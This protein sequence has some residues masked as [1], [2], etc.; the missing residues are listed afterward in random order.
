MT[1]TTLAGIGAY[2]ELRK[3]IVFTESSLKP[4]SFHTTV[5]EEDHTIEIHYIEFDEGKIDAH[6]EE[7]GSYPKPKHKTKHK[8]SLSDVRGENISSPNVLGNQKNIADMKAS[9]D[10]EWGSFQEEIEEKMI[11]LDADT[12]SRR[13][14]LDAATYYSD[15]F[16]LVQLTESVVDNNITL[17]VD[18]RYVEPESAFSSF[19][20]GS[21]ESV[22]PLFSVVIMN[23]SVEQKNWRG[24]VFEKLS[25]TITGNLVRAEDGGGSFFNI[26]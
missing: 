11:A 19:G 13:D 12:D 9:V 17:T 23:D 14:E 22:K 7:D 8:R 5:D 20:G 10:T 15:D 3:I 18:L 16:V 2:Q 21:V 25:K 6:D 24:S 4:F 26:I 1:K